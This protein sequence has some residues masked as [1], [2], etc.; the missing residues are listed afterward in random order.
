MCT[1]TGQALGKNLFDR[2]DPLGVLGLRLGLAA[3]VVLVVFRPR[4]VP[5]AA[6]QIAAVVGLGV[7]IA[8]I[9]AAAMA[10]Y[11][12][13]SR[14]LAPHL[15]HTAL[16]LALPLAACLG[17][18]AGIAS[19]GA[20]VFQ[21]QILL[22]AA[23]VAV[24]SAV[25]PYSLEMAALKRIPAGSAG[26]LLSLEPVVAALA[27]LFVLGETLSATQ[28]SAITCICVAAAVAVGSMGPGRRW[29]R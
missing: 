8:G 22:L 27:G 4:R 7:A 1:Q 9:S 15:G 18:P 20:A 2:L 21:P 24:L 25:I 12:L 11:L 29:H 28:W 17:L 14:A 6:P 26:I 5:R 16:A 19:N 13:L 10:A 3:A 23:M